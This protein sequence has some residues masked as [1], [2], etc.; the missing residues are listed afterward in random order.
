MI[1]DY[2]STY[3]IADTAYNSDALRTEIVSHTGV[4]VIC[5]QRNHLQERPY[6]RGLYKFRNVIERFHRLE[7]FRGVATRYDKYAN[8]YL[9]FVDFAAILITAKECKGYLE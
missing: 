3:V 8:R 1:V 2:S 7:R 6:D 9:T 5:P 4:A